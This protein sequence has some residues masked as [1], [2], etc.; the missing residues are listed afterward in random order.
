MGFFEE[1][2]KN[3]NLHNG[4]CILKEK[5]AV[6]TRS[7]HANVSESEEMFQK[8]ILKDHL[9][10]VCG[11]L[12]QSTIRLAGDTGLHANKISLS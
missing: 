8:L 5:T 10:S 12:L 7:E 11:N 9:V 4:M 1:V 3:C 6:V 2:V